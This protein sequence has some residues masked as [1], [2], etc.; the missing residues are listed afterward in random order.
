MTCPSAI[1][2]ARKPA[3]GHLQSDSQRGDPEARL[4][5]ATTHELFKA[6]LAQQPSGKTPNPPPGSKQAHST[7]CAA[8]TD[9]AH[10]ASGKINDY[11]RQTEDLAAVA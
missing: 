3:P 2:D 5:A 4:L 9:R 8:G 7:I 6:K 11:Y 10:P 1:P